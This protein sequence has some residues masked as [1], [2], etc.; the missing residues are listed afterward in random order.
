MSLQLSIHMGSFSHRII[1]VSHATPSP[2][3]IFSTQYS[4]FFAGPVDTVISLIVY[5]WY[6]WILSYLS[7]NLFNCDLQDSPVEKLLFNAYNPSD[8]FVNVKLLEELLNFHVCAFKN[9]DK[10]NIVTK[11][12]KFFIFYSFNFYSYS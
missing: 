1:T 3:T 5:F 7:W 2:D 10:N 4:S 9:P 6:W 11:I 8:I 12:T